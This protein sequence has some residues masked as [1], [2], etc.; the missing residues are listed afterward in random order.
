MSRR[1]VPAG[2]AGLAGLHVAWAAGWTWPAATRT[3]LAERVAGTSEFP[4]APLTLAVAGALGTA[5]LLVHRA[6]GGDDRRVVQAG[7]RAVAAVFLLRAAGG[8]ATDLAGGLETTFQQLDAAIYSPLCLALG[9]GTL[10][11]VGAAGSTG[12]TGAA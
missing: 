4:S 3:D 2:L 7:A 5:A 1:I 11:A 12:A 10:R 8:W 6:A 9:A